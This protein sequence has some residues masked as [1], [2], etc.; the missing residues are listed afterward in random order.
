MSDLYNLDGRDF[1]KGLSIAVLS[2]VITWLL[3]ALNTPGFD[4]ATFSWIEGVRIAVVATLAYL[5][6]NFVTDEEGKL[7]GIL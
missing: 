4:F 7:G 2:A 5:A 3:Q 1:I 6:K